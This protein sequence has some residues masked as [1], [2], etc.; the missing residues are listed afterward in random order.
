[1]DSLDGLGGLG[2]LRAR[3]EGDG[4]T[5]AGEAIRFSAGFRDTETAFA[6][7]WKTGAV[8]GST[9]QPWME[10]RLK[11]TARTSQCACPTSGCCGC[12]STRLAR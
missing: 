4:W 5:L 12:F 10:V 2:L 3:V 11:K 8:N 1:M 7:L 9:W 6:G